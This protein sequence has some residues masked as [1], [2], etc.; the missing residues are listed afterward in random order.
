M[1]F[2]EFGDKRSLGEIKLAAALFI[3]ISGNL[4][5]KLSQ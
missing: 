4:L 1:V 5:K 3:I 2:T